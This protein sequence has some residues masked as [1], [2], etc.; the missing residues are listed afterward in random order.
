M[1]FY[2]IRL[3]IDEA[4]HVTVEKCAP[5]VKHL[6]HSVGQLSVIESQVLECDIMRP[7]S[8]LVHRGSKYSNLFLGIHIKSLITV[9][10]IALILQTIYKS[11][12]ALTK[13]LLLKVVIFVT[14]NSLVHTFLHHFEL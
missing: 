5:C 1:L 7:C 13:A 8:V 3:C 14:C 6:L 4:D 12:S 2:N 9:T 10:I 11:H